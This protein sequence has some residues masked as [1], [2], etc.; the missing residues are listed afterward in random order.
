VKN[1]AIYIAAALG[2]AGYGALQQADRDESGT[3]V[4]EG[5]VDAF[6]MRVGDCFDDASSV[7]SDGDYEVSSV[8]GVPCAEPHDNEVFAVFDLELASFPD[9]DGMS[10]LAFEACRDR[11]E[12]FVAR[13]SETSMLDITALY[14]TR[15]SWSRQG[16]REVVCAV[17]EMNTEK[18]VG[19]VKGLAM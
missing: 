13:D 14:P 15:E 19:S 16:D 4:G 9:D 18:L 12:A 7:P 17:Y 3:I 8:P 2:I 1:W 11:F 10:E 5:T 6:A